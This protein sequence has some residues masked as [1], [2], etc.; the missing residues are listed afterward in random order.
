MSLDANVPSVLYHFSLNAAIELEDLLCSGV[1]N[2]TRSRPRSE[3]KSS[4]L[5]SCRLRC[6]GNYPWFILVIYIP[7]DYPKS[8][9]LISRGTVVTDQLFQDSSEKSPNGV[10]DDN[11]LFFVRIR[12][13]MKVWYLWFSKTGQ[14]ELINISTTMWAECSTDSMNSKFRQERGMICS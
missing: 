9:A 1:C 6:K 10:L 13:C 12:W 2:S 4:R 5:I 7:V 14:W 8:Q 3:H 11:H